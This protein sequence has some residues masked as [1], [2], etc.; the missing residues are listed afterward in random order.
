[1]RIELP[2]LSLILLV[3]PAGAGKST[4]AR[5]H[6]GETEVV[7]SDACRALV[8]DDPADQ[9]ATRDAF[10]LLHLIVERRLR[11]GRFTVVDATN[12]QPE[13]R[14]PLLLLAKRAHVP[15]FAFLFALPERIVRARDRSRERSVGDEV[16][17]R[18]LF[19]LSRSH[20][21]RE[22]FRRVVVFRA[23]EQVDEAELVRVRLP[24]DKAE[25]P[26]PF[27]VIGDL[28][29]CFDELCALLEKLGYALTCEEGRWSAVHP[30]GRRPVFVGDLVDRGPRIDDTLRFVMDLVG[31]GQGLCVIGNHEAKLLR[32]LRGHQVSV[33]N[34]LEETLE[35]LS[36]WDEAGLER[37]DRFLDGLPDHLVL[38]G[39]RLVVAHA[40]LPQR[41][42]GR[43]SPK[44]HA[45]ALFG[46]TSG[47]KD[48]RGYPI[49]RDWAAEYRGRALV[50]FGHTPVQ[51]PLWCNRTVN[52][53]TG[54]VFGGALTA[55][56]WPEER[57]V[58]VPAA[59]EYF[60]HDG[61]H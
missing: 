3:G 22:G 6:F 9:E 32:K 25:L 61:A 51:E 44:V 21:G 1:M 12:V 19:D 47:E 55:L 48:E 10:E 36:T 2:E 40:G 11:R 33:G 24:A 60:P 45:V 8:A 31:Q 5:L 58:S 59:R 38:D 34:G 57:T 26:G 56:Q 23:P 27:D 46:E 35:Q 43:D 50:V 54:C 13:A 15:A 4:F 52:V 20:L 41:L 53:D 18:H 7:S 37:I 14:R 29:G 17:D 49:R 30:E 16:I 42:Q 28:H 39:G